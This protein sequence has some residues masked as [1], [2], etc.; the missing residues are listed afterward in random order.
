MT[1]E[2]FIEGVDPYDA[3]DREAARIDAHCAALADDDPAWAQPSECEGWSVQD[4]LAHLLANEAYLAACLEGKV[5]RLMLEGAKRGAMDLD[6]F[7]ALGIADQAGKAP[8]ELLAE[9]RTKDAAS[10]AGFRSRD[11]GEVDTSIGEYS[12]RWQAFHLASEL[13]THADDMHIPQDD[14]GRAA[15]NTWRAPFSRFALTEAKDGLTVDQLPGGRTRLTG[16]GIDL[17]LDD[18]TLVTAVAGRSEDPAH[19]DLAAG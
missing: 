3:W 7:N 11:G 9:W 14:A 2:R 8:S 18:D 6:S 16:N 10:R 17:E 12:A 4:V 15:R 13:A 19:A 1:D 5:K